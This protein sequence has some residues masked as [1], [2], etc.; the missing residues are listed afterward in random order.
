MVVWRTKREK[1]GRRARVGDW[2]KTRDTRWISIAACFHGG[3]TTTEDI[4]NA[5]KRCDV[6]LQRLVLMGCMGFE[7]GTNRLQR[8]DSADVRKT[9]VETGIDAAIEKERLTCEAL[10]QRVGRHINRTQGL[11]FESMHTGGE[12][13][14][15]RRELPDLGD[16][17]NLGDVGTGCRGLLLK[18]T[19]GKCGEGLTEFR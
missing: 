18:E 15:R 13:I 10:V 3:S 4:D 8:L 12:D 5:T 9:S 2:G 11:S 19:G 1:R 16:L 7:L 14:H 6:L 17:G